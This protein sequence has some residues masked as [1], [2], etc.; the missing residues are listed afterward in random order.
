MIY[1]SNLRKVYRSHGWSNVVLD[2]VS[3]QLR[4]GQKLAVIGKNGAGKSTLIRL[5][6]KVELPTS[7]TVDHCMSVSWP[8]GFSGAF[9]GSLTGIDNMR[10]IARVYGI[11]YERMREFVENFSELG[12]FLYQPVKTYSAGMRARLAFAL[13]LTIE[14]KCYLIDEVILVGDQRFHA[15][16]KEH[17]FN[18]R[19]DRAL[20]LASH[21][22]GFVQEVCDSGLVLSAGKAHYFDDVREAMRAY[23]ELEASAQSR[24]NQSANGP[25]QIPEINKLAVPADAAAADSAGHPDDGTSPEQLVEA[26]YWHVLG[27]PPDSSGFAS[28]VQRL[29]TNGLQKELP[30]LIRDFLNGD[31]ARARLI[32]QNQELRSTQ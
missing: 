27:R 21:D 20:I 24:S 16:C 13:S 28:H 17:L 32:L 6:G 3:F 8:L 14:F 23:Q 25:A 7:G 31:E 22:A 2:D 19:A 26:L 10:F 29:K 12:Q 30:Y 5:L 9:Q 15:R 11:E 18:R 4:P 1:A